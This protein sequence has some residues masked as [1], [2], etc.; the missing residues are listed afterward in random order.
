MAGIFH[1]LANNVT[2]RSEVILY[3]KVKRIFG[4][5]ESAVYDEMLAELEV[6]SI[7]SRAISPISLEPMVPLELIGSANQPRSP[8]IG[9]RLPGVDIAL[10]VTV[11]HWQA[12]RDWDTAEGHISERLSAR[13][14]RADLSRQ[15]RLGLPLRVHSSDIEMITSSSVVDA[16]RAPSGEMTIPLHDRE[17]VL[18]WTEFPRFASLDQ[19]LTISQMVEGFGMGAIGDA[20]GHMF[21]LSSYP[22]LDERVLGEATTSLRKALD[23]KRRQAIEGIPNII[24]LGLGHPRLSWDLIGP[25]FLERIWP[26]PKYKWIT[27]L[28]A[29]T[30]ERAWDQLE[31]TAMI[32]FEWNPNA[33]IQAPQLLRDVA[34]GRATH[35]LP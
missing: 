16:L 14:R 3:E 11:W 4:E 10:E 29:Y 18:E 12:L 8:D 13:L 34:E 20:F 5:I 25:V 19:G 9:I 15:I 32:S 21:G 24:A 26:N 23:R 22:L 27:A 2:Q 7:L 6:A 17:A 1:Q 28:A 30:P 33:S 31:G 35:H